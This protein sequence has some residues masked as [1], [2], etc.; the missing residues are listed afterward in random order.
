MS[1]GNGVRFTDDGLYLLGIDSCNGREV[2]SPMMT[3]SWAIAI[4]LARYLLQTLVPLLVIRLAPA[5]PQA[6]GLFERSSISMLAQGIVGLLI[7][8]IALGL[9]PDVITRRRI[10]LSLLGL[11]AFWVALVAVPFELFLERQRNGSSQSVSSGPHQPAARQSSSAITLRLSSS[12]NPG[13][14]VRQL[15][16]PRL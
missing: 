14:G 12:L 11:I 2:V 15:V 9:R 7:L 6:V 4:F 16:P 3:A 10:C 1:T 5:G 8:W 13:S